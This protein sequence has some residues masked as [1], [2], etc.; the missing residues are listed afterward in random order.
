MSED[1]EKKS[2]EIELLEEIATA[3][4][5]TRNIIVTSFVLGLVF[6]AISFMVA[7]GIK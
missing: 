5:T 4:K 7:L 6:L 3:T 2:R 1:K